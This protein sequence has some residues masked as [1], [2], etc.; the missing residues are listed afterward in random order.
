[1]VL[2]VSEAGYVAAFC[3]LTDNQKPSK[4]SNISPASNASKRSSTECFLS[5]LLFTSIAFA[6]GISNT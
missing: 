1:M 4:D 3:A 6:P 5:V 2:V